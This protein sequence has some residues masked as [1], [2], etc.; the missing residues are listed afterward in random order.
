M[1]IEFDLDDENDE[2]TEPA[3]NA[4]E[5]GATGQSSQPQGQQPL[6]RATPSGRPNVQQYLQ[7][8]QGAG[9][10]LAANITKNIQGQAN[11]V[12]QDVARTTEQLNTGTQPLE[13]ELGQQG[14]DFS[15]MAF[16]DP[17]A[18]LNQQDQLTKFQRYQGQG[19]DA[20]IDNIGNQIQER[21]YGIQNDYDKLA[22]QAGSAK[23]EAGRF[24]L[25]RSSLGQPTYNRGAQKLDQLFL[26]AQ[27]GVN[28]GL[29]GSLQGIQN[30]TN[31]QVAG[32]DNAK[33]AKLNALKGFSSDRAKEIQ[34]MLSGGL[35]EGLE[36]NINERGFSDIA[37]SN[38]AKEDAAR[39]AVAK[40]QPMRDRLKSN[41]LIS[42]DVSALGLQEGTSLYDVN[43]DDFINQNNSEITSAN[44]ADPEE[45]A[46]YRALQQLAGDTSG[47]I[48]G[49]ATTAGGHSPYQFNSD[50]FAKKLADQKKFYEN[51]RYDELK[52][53]YLRNGLGNWGQGEY[54]DRLYEMRQG[55]Q[56]STNMDGFIQATDAFVNWDA[57]SMGGIQ[58]SKDFSA[59]NPA[60]DYWNQLQGLRG[61]TVN[62]IPAMPTSPNGQ[63]DYSQ[64]TAPT[65]GAGKG[66]PIPGDLSPEDEQL[67]K[68]KNYFNV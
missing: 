46:R 17:S 68:D 3:V 67:L 55:I 30:Q 60:Y 66:E 50:E 25:L 16:K 34:G 36:D 57:P 27:P 31:Q 19:A 29:Q 62:S 58:A 32:L 51:T 18:I 39:A 20:D 24:D 21:Q 10:R 22:Q 28:R 45:F 52:N 26:Q 54:Q 11:R 33:N 48:Y 41:K 49:G 38:K 43:L 37:A 2:A 4:P 59:L 64:I 15:K 13:T 47:D 53:Q 44:V 63:I 56:A 6:N 8:N 35:S 12:G 40:V 61:N 65:G 1:A 42:D 23:T 5:T 14:S 9:D 7:A